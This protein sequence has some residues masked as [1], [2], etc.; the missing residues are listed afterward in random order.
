MN[1]DQVSAKIFV[2][3]YITF[4]LHFIFPEVGLNTATQH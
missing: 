4:P 3:I 2:E 1:R